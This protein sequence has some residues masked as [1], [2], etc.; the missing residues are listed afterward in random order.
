M[1]ETQAG[2]EAFYIERGGAAFPSTTALGE[3]VSVSFAGM[4]LR[5]WF[6][7]QALAG[8]VISGVRRESEPGDGKHG[9]SG[10]AETAYL[11]ADAMLAAREQGR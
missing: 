8:V 1:S 10:W 9:L 4:T 2:F 6:A 7:G 11:L 5:D 3:G